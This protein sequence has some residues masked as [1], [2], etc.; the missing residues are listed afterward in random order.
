MRYWSDNE[1]QNNCFP[2]PNEKR[3]DFFLKFAFVAAPTYTLTL[4]VRLTMVFE[5]QSGHPARDASLRHICLRDS[6]RRNGG[7]RPPAGGVDHRLG[8]W[9]TDQ[10]EECK[11][12]KWRFYFSVL[13]LSVLYLSVIY[14]SVIYLSVIYL[15][16]ARN[17]DRSP[18]GGIVE[19]SCK[20]V[21]SSHDRTRIFSK[22]VIRRL[23]AR[24][25]PRRN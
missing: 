12:E 24:I 20:P 4:V 18:A 8:H 22:T 23:C 17:D 7:R 25:T 16:G 21:A 6:L 3:N 15:S 1:E 10:T 19:R 9:R 11:T 13:Y 5:N 14:L 2:L